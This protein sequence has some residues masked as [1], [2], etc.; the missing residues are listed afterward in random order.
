MGAAPFTFSVHH[1]GSNDPNEDEDEQNS[2]N[3]FEVIHNYCDNYCPD[4]APVVVLLG[5]AGCQEKHLAKYDAIYEKKGSV[6]TFH[7]RII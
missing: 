5:W 2:Q 6:T 3:C 4:S 1:P 7:Y